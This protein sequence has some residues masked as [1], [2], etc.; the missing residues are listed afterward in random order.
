MIDQLQQ[1]VLD[2]EASGDP[3]R[4]EAAY[5]LLKRQR[6]HSARM[7]RD[8]SDPRDGAIDVVL[9]GRQSGKTVRAI[10]WVKAGRRA[11]GSSSRVLVVWSEAYGR[12]LVY[13]A[14]GPGE[15]D[16]L[17]PDEVISW[18]QVQNAHGRGP[19]L[20]GREVGIDDTV[21]ILASI[22]G[23]GSIAFAT[24]MTRNPT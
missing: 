21:D 1:N 23:V 18:R 13:R 4:I 12:E 7:S 14:E 6:V 3:N 22:L 8:L 10:E 9:G 2:A 24:V 17:R 19:K 20:D 15:H 11:D 16:G 5:E